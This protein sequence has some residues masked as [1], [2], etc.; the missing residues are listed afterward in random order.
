LDRLG[1][2]NLKIAGVRA[3]FFGRDELDLSHMGG[4]GGVNHVSNQ[5]HCSVGKF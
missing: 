1:K 5:V 4:T 3:S 2:R